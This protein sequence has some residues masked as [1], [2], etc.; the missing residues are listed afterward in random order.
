MQPILLAFVIAFSLNPASSSPCYCIKPEVPEAFARAQ[1]VFVGEVLEIAEPTTSDENAR[2]QDRVHTVR[3][4][5]EKSWKGAHFAP[6]IEVLADQGR[7]CLATVTKGEKYLVYADPVFK[8]GAELGDFIIM[9]SCSRTAKLPPSDQ[10][11][12]Q[13]FTKWGLEPEDGAADLRKLDAVITMPSKPRRVNNFP[14][15]AGSMSDRNQLDHQ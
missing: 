13:R 5:I 6:E 12:E 14:T 8:N 2:L 15:F 7:G 11:L 3:F 9:D 4:K 10:Q 1:A